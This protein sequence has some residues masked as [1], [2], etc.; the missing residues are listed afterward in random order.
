MMFKV[1]NLM[2]IIALM[3]TSA[4]VAD[5]MSNHSIDERTKKIGKVKVA[6][7]AAANAVAAEPRT[8]KAI[9]EQFCMACHGTGMPGAARIGD[10]AA[11]AVKLE[12]GKDVVLASAI[13]G[14]GIMP[15]RGT[16]MDCT[17]DELWS[18]IEYMAN[19]E[20]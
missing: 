20:K 17:D 3:C 7:P 5:H 2:A 15:P 10:K 9:T 1:K 4:L 14:K 13:K 11:W 18:A 8:G 19:F 16:C 6:K 12:P